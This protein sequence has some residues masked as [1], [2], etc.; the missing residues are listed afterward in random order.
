[1]KRLSQ[2]LAAVV[3]A[4]LVPLGIGGSA[5]A[6]STCGVGFTGPDSQNM[7]TSVDS[8]RC[9]VTNTNTVD[10]VN[11]TEQS[12]F[13]GAVS[14][15]GNTTGGGSTSGSATNTSG[16]TFSVTII[17]S[18]SEDPADSTC[19]AAVVVPAVE[20]PVTVQP[21]KAATTPVQALPVTSGESSLFTVVIVAVAIVVGAL[22]AAGAALAYRH[23]RAE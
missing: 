22:L 16:T 11:S 13:S 14:V 3:M 15:S 9:S 17:N 10:I 18:T 12:V 1:M 20:T 21:T 23:L 2:L 5:S 4:I 19:T 8:Y 7:C 6:A